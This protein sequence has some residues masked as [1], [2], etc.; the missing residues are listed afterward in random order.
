MAF[1]CSLQ[2][3]ETYFCMTRIKNTIK[4]HPSTNK[5]TILQ[6]VVQP[7]FRSPFYELPPF[8]NAHFLYCGV[9]Q[10]SN[11][12]PLF[13]TADQSQQPLHEPV[14]IY[15]RVCLP[16]ECKLFNMETAVDKLEAMV[17]CVLAN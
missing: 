7:M 16:E 12:L 15:L 11:L 3:S 1:K 17:R 4:T 2:L 6:S 8:S 9:A 14:A 10:L 13:L 5:R